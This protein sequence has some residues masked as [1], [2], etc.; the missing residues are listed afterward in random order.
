MFGMSK[1][2]DYRQPA[3]AAAEAAA[4]GP[5]SRA[6]TPAC[7][8]EGQPT[9]ARRPWFGLFPGAPAYRPPPPTP[10]APYAAA[11]AAGEEPAAE[12]RQ[13]SCCAPVTI[14]IRRAE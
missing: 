2:P 4:A 5:V 1:T 7:R 14:I 11:E 8:G 12:E 10:P 13:V 9:S 3:A 6:G